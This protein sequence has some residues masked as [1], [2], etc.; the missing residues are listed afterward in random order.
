MPKIN[1]NQ[2]SLEADP[3]RSMSQVDGVNTGEEN[4]FSMLMGN[5]IGDEDQSLDEGSV[6]SQALSGNIGTERNPLELTLTPE[7]ISSLEQE[8]G[9]D[10][11]NVDLSKINLEDISK[12]DLEALSELSAEGETNEFSKISKKLGV[13]FNKSKAQTNSL[14]NFSV[15][16]NVENIK[17]NKNDIDFKNNILEPKLGISKNLKAYNAFE[18]TLDNNFI[19]PKNESAAM[20]DE[21]GLSNKVEFS[22]VLPESSVGLK[23]ENNLVSKANTNSIDLSQLN[24]SSIPDSE[25][26]S[27]ITNHLDKMKLTSS[28]ELSVTVKHNELGQFQINA[29]EMGREADSK[30][31]LEILS[32]SKEVQ[33]FFKLNE[34][35]LSSVLSEKGFSLS[36]FKVSNSNNGNFEKDLD[37]SQGDKNFSG[38]QQSRRDNQN[39][40]SQRRANLWQQYQEKLGA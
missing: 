36:S 38:Q 26:I 14:E 9:L 18:N 21:A 30:L 6:L 16:K 11:K 3:N 25:I 34:Q 32:N 37:L 39:Q 23:V 4:L 19:K 15:D 5:I 31:N 12:E 33:N 17:G 13:N 22:S 35:N 8:L 20:L 1:F 40:D 28:K 10:L 2:N 7:Q 27:E 24:L 29:N